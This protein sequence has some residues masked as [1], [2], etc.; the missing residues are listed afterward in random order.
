MK[1]RIC[2]ECVFSKSSCNEYKLKYWLYVLY[3]VPNIICSIST[4]LRWYRYYTMYQTVR[5]STLRWYRYDTMFQTQYAPLVAHWCGIGTIPCSKHS[6]LH[7]VLNQVECCLNN[8]VVVC[9]W[10]WSSTEQCLQDTR[11]KMTVLELTI[12][13]NKLILYCRLVYGLWKISQC[14]TRSKLSL[15]NVPTM[16][17]CNW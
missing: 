7:K 14:S 12:P 2:W 6:T 15:N 8:K 5:S 16:F 3:H 17:S 4:T 13:L 10:I 1:L 9:T 11:N